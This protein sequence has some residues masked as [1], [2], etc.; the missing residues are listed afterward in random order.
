L[1]KSW[2]ALQSDVRLVKYLEENE[3]AM[4]AL[5]E[6]RKSGNELATTLAEIWPGGAKERE[7]LANAVSTVMWLGKRTQTLCDHCP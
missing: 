1:T 5:V 4:S 3:P 6:S 2:T 7:E